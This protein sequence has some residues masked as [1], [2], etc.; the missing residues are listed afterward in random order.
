[1]ILSGGYLEQRIDPHPDDPYLSKHTFHIRSP[2]QVNLIS[3]DTYH[4]VAW[5]P[6]TGCWTVFV[7]GPVVQD[8]GFMDPNTGMYLCKEDVFARHSPT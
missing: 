3:R 7:T 4:R 8:W 5:V 6:T 1:M 2:G